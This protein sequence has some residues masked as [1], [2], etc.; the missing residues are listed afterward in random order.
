MQCAT[1]F[2]IWIREDSLKQPISDYILSF[3]LDNLSKYDNPTFAHKYVQEEYTWK[4]NNFY[5]QPRTSSVIYGPYFYIEEGS[6]QS[7]YIYGE[8]TLLEF[9]S[10]LKAISKEICFSGITFY[11]DVNDQFHVF[12]DFGDKDVISEFERRH[13]DDDDDDDD[14]FM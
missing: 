14:Y 1:S 7:G 8:D 2:T 5:I 13:Y 3:V 4:A 10:G 11:I 9:A 6:G 12:S